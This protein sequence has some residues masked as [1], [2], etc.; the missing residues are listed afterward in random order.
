[1]QQQL[2]TKFAREGRA[3]NDLKT[4]LRGPKMVEALLLF[5]IYTSS[6]SSL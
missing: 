6:E 3:G 5:N 1:M 4:M 2:A